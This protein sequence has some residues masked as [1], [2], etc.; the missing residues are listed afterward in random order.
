MDMMSKLLLL[1]V[2]RLRWFHVT[3]ALGVLMV[4]YGVV[5]DHTPD[6]G[7]IILTGAGIAGF[8]RVKSSDEKK[9][10]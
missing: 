10:K 6:R 1:L 7:T 2:N 3:R 9:K 5:V 8:D 4:A